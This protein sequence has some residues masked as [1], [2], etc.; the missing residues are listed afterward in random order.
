V[1]R[2]PVAAGTTGADDVPDRLGGATVIRDP[3]AAGTT[4][5]DDVPDRLGGATVIRDPV[6]AGTTGTD[7]VP[8]R[9]GGATVIRD[10]VPAGTTGTDDVPD[11]LGGATVIR[12]RGGRTAPA[13][14]AG[15]LAPPVSRR[16]SRAARPAPADT[17]PRTGRAFTARIADRPGTV[18][19][20]PAREP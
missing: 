12:N 16:P 2:D 4:G 5:A 15:Y 3:V 19:G 1:I 20:E 10:P 14:R 18:R 7:D 11:R 9:L 13:T 6:A 8:D 17:S